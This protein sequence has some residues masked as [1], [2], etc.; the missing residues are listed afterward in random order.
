MA[1]TPGAVE[2]AQ[3]V[4]PGFPKCISQRQCVRPAMWIEK[5]ADFPKGKS[6][7]SK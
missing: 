7:V 1:P 6:A 2:M 5:K 4:P 3:I